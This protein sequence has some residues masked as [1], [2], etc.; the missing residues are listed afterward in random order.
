MAQAMQ[1]RFYRK[2]TRYASGAFKRMK[3][4]RALDLDG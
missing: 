1:Q 2:V 4:A 3:L